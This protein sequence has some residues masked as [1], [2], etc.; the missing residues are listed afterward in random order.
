MKRALVTGISGQCAK[1]VEAIVRSRWKA[2]TTHGL[3]SSYTNR[4]HRKKML[5]FY[6]QFM[7]KGDLCFDVGAHMGSRTDVFLSLGARVVCVEP[8]EAC[9]QRLYELFRNRGD[10]VVLGKAV[11]EHDGY[12]ELAICDEASVISTMSFK[13]MSEGRFSR[14][15][16]WT[17]TQ[18]VP[19]IT[20]DNLITLYG[21][22]R[23]C[24]IDVEG[25]EQ[26]VLKGL[27]K[28]IRFL[29]FEFHR[30][31]LGDAEKCMNHLRSLGHV[32]FNCS[33]GES[34]DLMFPSW[35]TSEKLYSELGSTG[36]ELLWGDIYASFDT[37]T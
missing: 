23:F 31:F 14:D 12:G 35:V 5:N 32:E 26:F 22:P 25:Y 19:M 33:I 30:E 20:L 6:S 37:L 29:S 36:D 7:R 3:L 10:V 1:R 16:K 18:R 11:G 13:W 21:P 15:H 28:P 34:M 27:T 2:T 4:R 17:R 9:V 8:Q 24:K